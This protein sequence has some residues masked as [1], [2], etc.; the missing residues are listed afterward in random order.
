MG[1]VP[2]DSTAILD[3]DSDAALLPFIGFQ[4][5]WHYHCL[6]SVAALNAAL[7]LS[8]SLVE[9]AW[10]NKNLHDRPIGPVQCT[11]QLAA[12][13]AAAGEVVYGTAR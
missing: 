7:K 4:Y 10:A 1:N 3:A 6:H 11:L 2:C 5:C 12:T 8:A 9:C 13:T